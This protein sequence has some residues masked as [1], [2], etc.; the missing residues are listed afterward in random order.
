LRSSW[1]LLL[2]TRPPG[3]ITHEE[4]QSLCFLWSPAFISCWLWHCDEFQRKRRG[5]KTRLQIT[6]LTSPTNILIALW[7]DAVA[8]ACAAVFHAASESWSCHFLAS[9]KASGWNDMRVATVLKCRIQVFANQYA[10]PRWKGSNAGMACLNNAQATRVTAGYGS[11]ESSS[12]MEIDA[13]IHLFIYL[14]C[15]LEPKSFFFYFYYKLN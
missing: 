5:T 10:L 3:F 11:S 2:E 13:F 8:M 6:D 4:R 15:P 12:Q 7:R 9:T 14:W 1:E